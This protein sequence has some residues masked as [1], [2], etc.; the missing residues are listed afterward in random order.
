M[1]KIVVM[2]VAF[3]G[4][5]LT[6]FADSDQPQSAP[7]NTNAVRR[8]TPEMR[9][10][11]RKAKL[12]Y[13]GGTIREANTAK[14]VFAVLNSQTRVPFKA[15]KEL[16]PQLDKDFR[17]MMTF[18]D[19]NGINIG[20]V[21]DSIKKAGGT[22]GV[23]I[24]ADDNLP[25]LVTAPEAGWSLVNVT[26]IASGAPDEATVAARVRKEVL[27]GFAFVSGGAYMTYADP[28]MRDVCKPRD[29]DLLQGESFGAEIIMHFM[30]SSRF[31]GLK[32]WN[33]STYRKACEAGWAPAPTND[34]QKAVW[35]KVHAIPQK[36]MKIEYDPKKGR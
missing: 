30:Q 27:R 16:E 15:I 26:K 18:K 32:P 6:T 3:V 36:P 19:V 4:I 17:I 12:K 1:N 9:E 8:M 35:D 33:E 25:M 28:L 20:N 31:Y 24:I 14:G 21:A 10:K 2:S 5:V 22:V 11:I 23:A 7:A 34:I 29:L 13:T